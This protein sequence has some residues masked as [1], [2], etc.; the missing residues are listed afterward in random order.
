MIINIKS[1]EAKLSRITLFGKTFFLIWGDLK[2]YQELEEPKSASLEG[3][4]GHDYLTGR[5]YKE[6]EGQ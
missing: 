2:D 1:G 3:K 5:L 4:D 6:K